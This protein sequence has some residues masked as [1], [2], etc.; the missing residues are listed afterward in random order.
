[1]QYP[2]SKQP[3][4]FD[5]IISDVYS[6]KNTYELVN[7]DRMTWGLVHD[8]GDGIEEVNDMF[9]DLKGSIDSVCFLDI[10]WYFLLP[11]KERDI[12]FGC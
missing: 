4:R 1:M 10:L 8:T 11:I 9:N 3:K 5:S 6:C 7:E 2:K 12:M